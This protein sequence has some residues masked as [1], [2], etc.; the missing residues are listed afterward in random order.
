MEQ[1]GNTI[2]NFIK[3]QFPAHYREYGPILVSFCTEYYRWLESKSVARNEYFNQKFN[4]VNIVVDSANV[5]GTGS[6]F[7]TNFA[8]GDMIAV[9]KNEQNDDFDFYTIANIANNTFLT[10]RSDK[11]PDFSLAKTKYATVSTKPNAVFLTRNFFDIKDI[12]NTF[13]EYVVYFKEK[14]LKHLQFKTITNTKTLIK[15]SLDLY[16]SKGTERSVDLLYKIVFGK[17][18]KVYYPGTDLFRLSG[19]D[20]FIPNYLELSLSSANKNLINKQVVGTQSG[21]IAFVEEIIRRIV[22]GK[23][24][25]IAYISAI[26]GNFITG[27]KVYLSDNSL[28]IEDCPTVIGSLNQILVD[29]NGA[30]LNFTQNE[31]INVTS[32]RGVGGKAK[33]LSIANTAGK[34]FFELADGGY[35]YANTIQ[36]SNTIGN[37]AV[38]TGNT[39]VVGDGTLFQTEYTNG[40]YISVWSNSTSYETQ[41]VGAIASNTSLTVDAA[42][43]FTNA[44]TVAAYTR[45]FAQTFISDSILHLSNVTISTSYN[46]HDYFYFL[47]TL[48][49]PLA[50]LNY[51]AANGNF[52]VGETIYTYS[53][54]GTAKVLLA[55]KKT[56]TSGTLTVA[57][58]TGD[59]DATNIYTEANVVGA[60]LAVAN[61]YTDISATA[62]VVG[63][64]ANV[65]I[66]CNTINGEFNVGEHIVQLSSGAR[67]EITDM[68]THGSNIIFNVANSIGIYK[69]G[70]SIEEEELVVSPET[71][72]TAKVISTDIYVGVIN[73]NNAFLTYDDN[74]ANTS[75]LQGT[76]K[77]VSRGSSA[78]VLFSNTIL[79][80]EEIKYNTDFIYPY[81]DLELAETWPFP[82]E[83]TSN[84]ST[85]IYDSLSFANLTVGKVSAIVSSTPGADYNFVPVIRLHEPTTYRYNHTDSLL[86]EITDTTSYEIGELITQDETGARGLI[87]SI[88][89]PYLFVQN[90]RFWPNGVF[91]E[92]SSINTQ[93]VGTDSGTVS[94]VVSVAFIEDAPRFG[95]DISILYNL[96][97]GSGAITSV[98]VLDSGFGFVNGEM[99]TLT[100]LIGNN[101]AD[102]YAVDTTMGTGSGYYKDTES[103]LS[104]VKRLSDGY[105]WQEYSYDVRSGVVS[106]FKS[107]LKNVI[108]VA[109]TGYFDTLLFDTINNTDPSFETI[110]TQ[111]Q[112]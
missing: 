49:E 35:G 29:V 110:F 107:I 91:I 54:A 55:S 2:S 75:Y 36:V 45:Y 95:H 41:R 57:P 61:G 9:C 16:R 66:T 37:V 20:W 71:G 17:P 96:V 24:I 101:S 28:K 18:A 43:S 90:L 87:Q 86:M 5:V 111:T 74:R 42:F 83:P 76:V 69:S 85:I 112:T 10:L 14:Y 1:I 40:D 51:E 102:G 39:L 34:V 46:H 82:A 72:A 60:A 97:V 27:E 93:I 32:A 58:L 15:H 4:T 65:I 63:T 12:D 8:N 11:L 98:Q 7:Q 109:G 25:E 92:T 73:V 19:G 78:A 31:I 99:V 47:D 79:Y 89:D 3:S 80:P 26:R 50:L 81:R 6:L 59:V 70:L 23:V 53:P 64:Y 44:E 103:F 84:L 62:N 105:Y 106:E 77:S 38:E 13:D 21:A 94:N 52:V 33:V 104:N 108:H 56:A 48:T 88:D 68:F 30:G 67:G 22:A 100:S